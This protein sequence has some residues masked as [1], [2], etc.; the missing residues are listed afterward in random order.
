MESCPPKLHPVTSRISWDKL[1]G[2]CRLRPGLWRTLPDFDQASLIEHQYQVTIFKSVEPVGDHES[3]SSC[4]EPLSCFHD[5]CF[6]VDVHGTGRLIQ[7]QNRTIP[8][9]RASQGNALA[10]ASRNPRAA[11]ASLGFVTVRQ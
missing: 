11:F 2:S 5:G 9:E 4:H 6:G 7:N 3:G 10:F 8:Q 1:L